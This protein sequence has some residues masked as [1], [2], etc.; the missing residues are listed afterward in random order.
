MRAALGRW[1]GYGFVLG[2]GSS[3]FRFLRGL[4][5]VLRCMSQVLSLRLRMVST[6]DET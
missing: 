2:R 1:R 3:G 5:I 4:G 6:W